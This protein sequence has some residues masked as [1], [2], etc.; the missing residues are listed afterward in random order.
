MKSYPTMALGYRVWKIKDNALVPLFEGPAWRPGKNLAY[1][2]KAAH[3]APALDCHCG[4]NAYHDLKDAYQEAQASQRN[5]KNLVIGAVLAKGHLEI[6][7][8]GFRAE[9]AQ[10]IGLW[11]PQ[12]QSEQLQALSVYYQVSVFATSQALEASASSLGEAVSTSLRPLKPVMPPTPQVQRLY[13]LK[14]HSWADNL[15]LA[16][17]YLNILCG[18]LALLACLGLALFLHDPSWLLGVGAGAGIGALAAWTLVRIGQA[19]IS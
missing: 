11:S 16:A 3:R 9:E 5:L 4:F 10:V 18:V 6:H 1:C 19:D 8:S 13:P 2:Q 15:L 12:G 7:H 14:A 17:A